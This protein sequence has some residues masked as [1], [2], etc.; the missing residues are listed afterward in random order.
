MPAG[1]GAAEVAEWLL[2]LGCPVPPDEVRAASARLLA[3]PPPGGAPLGPPLRFLASRVAGEA[4]LQRVR[5]NLALAAA[6]R[7]GKQ[8]SAGAD[9]QGAAGE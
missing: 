4:E 6:R 7:G 8:T 9:E 5:R 2:A 1:E 3:P